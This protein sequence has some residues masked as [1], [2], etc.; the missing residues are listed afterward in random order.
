VAAVLRAE[1][2]A[3]LRERIDDRIGELTP[4]NWGGSLRACIAGLN[5]YLRGWLGF[6][7]ICTG[8]AERTM[9]NLDARIRRRLRAIR[10][11]HWK[12]KR[13]IAQRL[14]RLGMDRATAWRSVYS[15]RKSLWALSLYP[16]NRGL[17]NAYFAELGL[18]S[19]LETWKAQNEAHLVASAGV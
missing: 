15:G 19:L 17:R 9:R 16:G 10:M 3:A 7:G 14:V 1:E 12:R 8:S 11:K 2:E 13:T 5:G 6:F 4:R 18:L